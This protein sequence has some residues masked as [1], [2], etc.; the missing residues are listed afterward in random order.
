MS[1]GSVNEVVSVDTTCLLATGKPVR[2]NTS[3]G[4]PSPEL[5]DRYLQRLQGAK[6]VN[7]EHF[8]RHGL[9]GSH[10][11]A[12][13]YDGQGVDVAKVDTHLAMCLRIIGK[14]FLHLIA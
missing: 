10:V 12:I 3:G 9:M 6:C 11:R 1:L 2:N 5:V 8:R 14:V 7:W 13:I 4:H